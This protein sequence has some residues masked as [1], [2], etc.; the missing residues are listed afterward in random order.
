MKELPEHLLVVGIIGFNQLP[1]LV[2]ILKEYFNEIPHIE[3]RDIKLSKQNTY[4]IVEKS[5]S[6][7]RFILGFQKI[8]NTQSVM[9]YGIYERSYKFYYLTD[10]HSPYIVNMPVIVS[11]SDTDRVSLRN[12]YYD[13]L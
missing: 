6:M 7:S 3:Y 11:L 10:Q 4:Y 2:E 8:A 13:N 12:L 9:R 5:Y 1:D